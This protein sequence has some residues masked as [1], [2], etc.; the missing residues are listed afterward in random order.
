LIEDPSFRYLDLVAAVWRRW[1]FRAYGEDPIVGVY[2][3]DPNVN[4]SQPEMD[5]RII[6]FI[7]FSD[8]EEAF[9][10]YYLAFQL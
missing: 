1:T 7:N 10:G 3:L 2:H 8:E 4:Y 9:L 6:A 5:Q